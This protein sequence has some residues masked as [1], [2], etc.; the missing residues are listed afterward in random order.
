M[1]NDQKRQQMASAA[2]VNVQRFQLDEIVGKWKSLID[3]VMV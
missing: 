1:S 2:L 3:E